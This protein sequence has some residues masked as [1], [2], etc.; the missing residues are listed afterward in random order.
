[1]TT[2]NRRSILRFP[3]RLTT[4]LYVHRRGNT[5]HFLSQTMPCSH[6]SSVPVV[7]TPNLTRAQGFPLDSSNRVHERGHDTQHPAAHSDTAPG[8]GSSGAFW[9]PGRKGGAAAQ[10]F[11]RAGMQY[12]MMKLRICGTVAVALSRT[13]PCTCCCIASGRV[14]AYGRLLLLSCAWMAKCRAEGKSNMF[15]LITRT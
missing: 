4:H 1:M 9:H 2:R 10:L 5:Q 14:P 3:V 7:L 15:G 8:G 13:V 12:R 6:F 11:F